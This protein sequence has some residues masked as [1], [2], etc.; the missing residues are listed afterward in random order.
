M[1][2][3]Q[4]EDIEFVEQG[5]DDLRRQAAIQQLTRKRNLLFWCA[6]VTTLCAFALFFVPSRS[7]GVGAAIGFAAAIHWMLVFKYESELRL[8]LMIGKLKSLMT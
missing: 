6:V 2:L 1:R 3:F 5:A 4:R 8:L 7:S